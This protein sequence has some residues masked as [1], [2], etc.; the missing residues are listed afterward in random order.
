MGLGRATG[1]GGVRPCSTL[2]SL[3]GAAAPASSDLDWLD[4]EHA[5]PS[6]HNLSGS[7]RR[8]CFLL[9]TVTDQV[10]ADTKWQD[11]QQY[12]SSGRQPAHSFV[13]RAAQ[14]AIEAVGRT[15]S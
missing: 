6:D 1:F 9:S 11:R 12:W 10:P 15:S 3:H 14:Q 4:A 2:A 5:G 13:H 7:Q 8:P